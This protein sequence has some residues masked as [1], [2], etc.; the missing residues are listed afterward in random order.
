MAA[1]SDNPILN[2]R[3]MTEL[4]LA[5]YHGEREWVQN[6][7]NGGL[8]PH[9]RDKNGYTPLHWAADMGIVDGEREEI[10]ALLIRAGSDVN[11]KDNSGRT[12]LTVAIKAGN[13]DIIRQL[14]EAGATE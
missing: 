7:L 13:E 6:C 9:A 3:G 5:A 1:N 2:D 10:T 11:A 4:H 8:S 14:R 12:V